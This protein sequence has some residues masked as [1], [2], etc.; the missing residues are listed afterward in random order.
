MNYG[1]TIHAEHFA[2][3]KLKTRERN[4]K[5]C[6]INILVIKVS[7]TGLIGMSKPCKHCVDNLQKLA[8]KKGYFIENIYFSN[9]LRQIEKWS[10]AKL[11]SDPNK[12][13]SEFYKKNNNESMCT[14]KY[15]S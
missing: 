9:Q 5:L 15:R 14:G 11:E 1:A 7:N 2:I 8:N 10:Y 4:K 12:H 13:I 3:N 6:K